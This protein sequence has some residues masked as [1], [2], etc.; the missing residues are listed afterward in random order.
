[1]TFSRIQRLD[2]IRESIKWASNMR[3]SIYYLMYIQIITYAQIC[4]YTVSFHWYYT[5][6]ENNGVKNFAFQIC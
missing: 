3:Y 1:M 4:L 5:C 2:N 6:L